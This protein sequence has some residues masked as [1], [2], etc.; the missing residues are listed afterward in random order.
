MTNYCTVLKYKAYNIEECFKLS[1]EKFIKILD[2]LLLKVGDMVKQIPKDCFI[3][4]DN[5]T[6]SIYTTSSRDTLIKILK[7]INNE[8]E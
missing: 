1:P 5:I 2:V 3:I 4:K 8:R 7:N 6:N